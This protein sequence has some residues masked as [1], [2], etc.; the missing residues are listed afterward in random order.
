MA[1]V[2]GP[3]VTVTWCLLLMYVKC[4]LSFIPF[5][6][7][8]ANSKIVKFS[9]LQIDESIQHHSNVLLDGFQMNGHSLG[10]VHGIDS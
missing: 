6:T 8:S 9:K 7:E 10:V 4:R 5:T 3:F 2:D 1:S